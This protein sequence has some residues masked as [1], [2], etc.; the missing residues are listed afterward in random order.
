MIHYGIGKGG[1]RKAVVASLLL[2][3]DEDSEDSEDLN[4]IKGPIILFR[5]D[6]ENILRCIYVKTILKVNKFWGYGVIMGL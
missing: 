5:L 3:V 4:V 2:P 6:Q 1:L